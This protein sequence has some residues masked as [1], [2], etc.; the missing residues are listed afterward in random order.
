MPRD[1]GLGICSWFQEGVRHTG[2]WARGSFGR[3]AQTL[4]SAI[5]TCCL[6]K[7]PVP[8]AELYAVH[9]ALR[10]SDPKPSWTGS[11]LLQPVLLPLMITGPK[12]PSQAHFL[13][14]MLLPPQGNAGFPLVL[15]PCIQAEGRSCKLGQGT[16]W[17]IINFCAS[18]AGC[19][20][21]H[22]FTPVC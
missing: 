8:T 16:L 5:N 21:V 2:P 13:I 1:A 19:I 9:E 4:V 6:S 22:S 20:S 12:L 10:F 14:F 15:L 18:S 7:C 11:V 17:L 3:T